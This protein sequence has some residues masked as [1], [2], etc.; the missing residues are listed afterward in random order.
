MA[1]K[2]KG[3][4]KEANRQAAQRRRNKLKG[5]TNQ[6]MTASGSGTRVIPTHDVI[7]MVRDVAKHGGE[8][9]FKTA[10]G[11]IQDVHHTKPKRGKDIKCFEDLHPRTQ[12]HIREISESNEEFQ[13][14]V[15][16]AIRYQH[17][18]PGRY[19]PRGI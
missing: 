12:A 1:Y 15:A 2:D 14:R 11:K 16:V 9:S 6:G 3:Q 4:Q 7:D 10:N 8:Y 17:L 5:M 13:R 18:F 19:E